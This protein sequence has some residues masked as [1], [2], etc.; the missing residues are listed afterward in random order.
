M[1]TVAQPNYMRTTYYCNKV[2]QELGVTEKRELLLAR[3]RRE[4]QHPR[5]LVLK[6]RDVKYSM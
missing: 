2:G 6:E 1:T 5:Q 4:N 3:R